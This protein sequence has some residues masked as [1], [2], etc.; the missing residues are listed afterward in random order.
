MKNLYALIAFVCC[1]SPALYSMDATT[2]MDHFRA[3]NLTIDEVITAHGGGVE[4]DTAR[5]FC[6]A[7]AIT[8]KDHARHLL[9]SPQLDFIKVEN[10][11]AALWLLE[12]C[13]MV[14]NNHRFAQE[15]SDLARG[16]SRHAQSRLEE[17]VE[18]AEKSDNTVTLQTSLRAL[19]VIEIYHDALPTLQNYVATMQQRKASLEAKLKAGHQKGEDLKKDTHENAAPDQQSHTP[20][21]S[22]FSARRLLLIGGGLALVAVI[23][24]FG[25]SKMQANKKNKTQARA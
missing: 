10:A 8:I 5:S 3:G 22:I 13:E 1:A 21:S 23:A 11:C 20:Y 14:P 9:I 24:L 7:N 2:I 16:I 17:A 12:K 15:A 4:L 6:S 18:A 25:Y 19:K